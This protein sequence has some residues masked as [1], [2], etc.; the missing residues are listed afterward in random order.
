MKT[1]TFA[2]TQADTALLACTTAS[3]RVPL[4]SL[5]STVRVVNDGA[6]TAF[7][8]FGDASVNATV[9]KIPVKAGATETFTKGTAAWVAG[10]TASGTTNMYFTAGEGL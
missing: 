9:S 5:S 1:K 8:Q 7:I 2:P 4:D 10:I 6:A 3:A